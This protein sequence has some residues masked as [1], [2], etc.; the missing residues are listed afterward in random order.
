MPGVKLN[1]NPK[2]GMLVQSRIVIY[3]SD[4]KVFLWIERDP[5]GF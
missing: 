3:I 1:Q 2:R 5:H 4:D